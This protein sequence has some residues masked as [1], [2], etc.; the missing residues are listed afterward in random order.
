METL[1]QLFKAISGCIVLMFIPVVA[2]TQNTVSIAAG[3]A[4]NLTFVKPDIAGNPLLAVTDESRWLNYNTT[5]EPSMQTYSIKVR[6]ESP[7]PEGLQLEIHA[8]TYMG[9][10]GGSPDA[11]NNRGAKYANVS[12][13]N[14]SEGVPAEKVAVTLIDQVLVYGIGAF[15]TGSGAYVGRQLTYTLS[16]SDYSKVRAASAG[17]NVVYTITQP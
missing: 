9:N 3:P 8:G 2:F 17:V 1:K 7:L 16:I 14:Y 11:P 6:L 12:G 15:N 10:G 13:G 4:V 5:I